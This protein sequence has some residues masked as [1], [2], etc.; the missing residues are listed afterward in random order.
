MLARD[1]SGLELRADPTALAPERLLV[2]EVRGSLSAFAGA[3]R[4]VSGLELVDEEELAGDEADK[5]PV[6]YLMV[7]D[8]RALANI[9][10]LWRR[11]RS[12]QL[13]TGET[14]WR[15]V[16]ALLRDLRPWG[17]Q[18]RVRAEEADIL[19]DIIADRAESEPVRIEVE[20]VFRSNAS[21]AA[22]AERETIDAIN[23]QGGRLVSRT[24]IDDIGYHALLVDLPL[25]AVR[26]IVAR[27]PEGIVALDS[28]M[29]IRPQSVSTSIDL[30][31]DSEDGGDQPGDP[32]AL[33]DPILAVLDGVPVARH[34][35]LVDHITLDDQFGLEPN[36]P[37]AGR[38]HGTAM[39]S[40]VIHGDRNRPAVPLPRRIHVVPVLGS[41]D[42][43]PADRLIVDVIYM[44][45][46][47]MREGVEAT[48]PNVIIVNLSLGN[49]RRPFHGQ[50][51]PWASCLI[52]S[53]IAMVCCLS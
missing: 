50:L 23:G 28:V 15:E 48:A 1:A 34:R 37:V 6:A 8:A 24:R 51:S 29:H 17:P 2:F 26:A 53:R 16:F 45:V 46:R 42:E 30:S 22:R 49:R 35:L 40:L 10:S 3:I 36:A 14:P 38:V 5:A 11:W 25:A 43:F 39:T 19:R 32:P 18:D 7:P 13:V 44:A 52:A 27:L 47:A 41:G 21:T 33:G 31:D 12:N 4:N 9:E 20:L